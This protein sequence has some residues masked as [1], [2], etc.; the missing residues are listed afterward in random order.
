MTSLVPSL[1]SIV[2][3][4]LTAAAIGLPVTASEAVTRPTTLYHQRA[5]TA[6]PV[7]PGFP[8]DYLGVTFQVPVGADSAHVHGPDDGH[9]GVDSLAVRFRTGGVWGDWTAVE[10]D[11]AQAVGQ[12]TGALVSGGDAEAYQVRGV[13][14]F[15]IAPRAAALNTTDGPAVTVGHRP[16]GTASA[17]TA[18]KSRADW[19]ADETIRTSS[20]TFAPLQVMTV[21][22]T[23][24]EN[25]DPDP[26]ARVRA[27][28]TYHVK[29]NGW[30]DIGY[31]A[32]ISE[33]GTVYEGRWSGSVSP[34]CVSSGGTG[35]EFGHQTTDPGSPVVTGAH[36]G[37]YNT[38]NFGVALLGTFSSAAPTTSARESLVSYLAELSKRHGVDPEAQVLYD[39][40]TNSKTV[41]RISGH[42]DF[43]ATECPGG[44]FYQDLPAVRSETKARMSPPAPSNTAPVVTISSPTVGDSYS[45][46]EASAGSGASVAFSASATDDADTSTLSWQWT[47]TSGAQVAATPSFTAILPVGTHAFRASAQDTGGLSGSD[48]ITVTVTGTY[49]V[50][51][52]ND[53][54]TNA[55]TRVGSYLD[56]HAVGGGVETLTEVES[57]GKL[58][59]RTSMLQ[60]RWAVPVTAGPTLTLVTNV[61]SVSSGD[62]D[63]FRFAYSSDG[64]QTYQD[65]FVVS[66]G[67]G[68]FSAPLPGVTGSKVLVRVLDTD[69]RA[70][71]RVLDSISVDHLYIRS[72]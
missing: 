51:V 2:T 54:A 14:S 55:G 63:S 22:H 62:G 57:G 13:P 18:C 44:V 64:G 71:N 45:T 38:G 33:S 16:R 46:K 69:R 41:H 19:G 25:N 37:G 52:A 20:R 60:H 43:G 27:I 5:V 6:A 32:L 40:G 65:L 9:P 11:G 1:R 50:W 58:S 30:A 10:E 66:S 23:A 42:R 72:E 35:W 4:L 28:Y 29:T 17:V 59:S 31:Q 48:T 68:V 49:T 53:E 61:S 34:S 70:G 56:T 15:A 7:E 39:N 47:D 3:L 12:W 8:V 21:H 24:T 36:A 67:G 26:D